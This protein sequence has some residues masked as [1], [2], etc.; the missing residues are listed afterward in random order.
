MTDEL[1]DIVTKDGQPTGKTALK[2]VIHKKGYHHN[3]AHLWLYTT[4]G[5]ILLAQRS[6][7]KVICPG[8]WD[9]SVAGHVDAGETTEQAIIRETQEEINLTLQQSDLHKIGV[10]PCFQTYDNGIIDNE[11]HHTFIAELRVPL[12]QLKPQADEVES[13][14]LVSTMAFKSLL[15]NSKN[16]NH[17]IASNLDYYTTIL[18]QIKI[19]L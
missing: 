6:F 15:K 9:V 1:I 13:L 8:L 2:S 11:F 5:E 14:K 18:D 19:V 3:T 12:K 16:N 17:F 4:A 10:F 7:T